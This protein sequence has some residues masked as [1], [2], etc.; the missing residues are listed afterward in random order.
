[1]RWARG[2]TGRVEN[3]VAADKT[4]FVFE[5]CEK[6]QA[7][8]DSPATCHAAVLFGIFGVDYRVG[9][10][11]SRAVGCPLGRRRDLKAPANRC[12]LPVAGVPD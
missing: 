12:R 1:V 9:H 5:D 8:C 11:R 3:Q 4:L 6:S 2:S 7:A 10:S